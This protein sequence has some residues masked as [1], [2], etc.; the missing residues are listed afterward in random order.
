MARKRTR[1][2]SSIFHSHEL[3]VPAWDGGRGFARAD[4]EFHGVDH[5]G[6]SYEGRVFVANA[7]ADEHTPCDEEH[8]YAG[9][10]YVFGHGGCF[11]EHGHCDVPDG[12]L[13]AFD[14]RPPHQLT[15]QRK[16]VIATGAIARI[17]ES[18]DRTSSGFQVTV[19]PVVPASVDGDA[20]TVEDVLLFDRVT[21]ATYL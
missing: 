16:V 17:A 1:G 14:Q 4:L 10:F 13:S 6:L 19:V 20:D 2:Q 15:P 12:P 21:L 9:S 18:A 3:P 7:G 5:A 8:G 11:G